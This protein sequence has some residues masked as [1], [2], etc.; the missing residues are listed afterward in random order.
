MAAVNPT[1][2]VDG[3]ANVPSRTEIKAPGACASVDGL[4]G[5]PLC[6]RGGEVSCGKGTPTGRWTCFP[7]PSVAERGLTVLT[8][9]AK[10]TTEVFDKRVQTS[11]ERTSC[12]SFQRTQTSPIARC[13][14]SDPARVARTI[15]FSVSP[16]ETGHSFTDFPW[17][18]SH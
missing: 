4:F 3:R 16:Y 7:Y 12:S 15:A 8:G 6:V 9:T 13:R 10:I 18:R 1:T 5:L 17:Q 2:D 11:Q 14:R